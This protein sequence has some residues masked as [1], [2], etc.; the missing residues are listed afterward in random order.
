MQRLGSNFNSV[1]FSWNF[2]TFIFLEGRGELLEHPFLHW[3]IFFFFFLLWPRFIRVL[4]DSKWQIQDGGWASSQSLIL[5]WLDWFLG[6]I[7]NLKTMPVKDEDAH[8]KTQIWGKFV[9][10]EDPF[11]YLS[12]FQRPWNLEETYLDAYL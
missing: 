8:L 7:R 10:F 1:D 5:R 11:N 2:V 6:S 3:S 9:T 4:I 12:C